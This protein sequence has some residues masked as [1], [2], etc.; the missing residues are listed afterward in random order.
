MRKLCWYGLIAVEAGMGLA[1]TACGGGGSSSTGP[2]MPTG[3]VV[4][5]ITVTPAT[6][7][8]GSQVQFVATVAGTGNFSTAV[9]WSIAAPSGSQL[10]PGTLSTSGLYTTPYPAPASVTVYATSTRTRTSAA[11]PL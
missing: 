6:A 2:V 11:K 9:S 5:S 8:I 3:P 1:L 7:T 10:S 4:T